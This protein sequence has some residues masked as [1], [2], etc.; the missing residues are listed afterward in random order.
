MVLKTVGKKDITVISLISLIVFFLISMKIFAAGVNDLKIISKKVLDTSGFSCDLAMDPRNG[1]LHVLWVSNGD[2]KHI[3]RYFSGSW[4]NI[5]T[6]DDGGRT[7]Y[8]QEE[9]DAA[10][11]C[12]AIDV[13]NTGKCHIVFA[14]AGGDIYYLNGKAGSWSEPKRIVSKG[15]YSIFTDIVWSSGNLYVVYEDSDPDKIYSV[16]C[17]NGKWGNPEM[18]ESG[19]YSE[20]SKGEDG[21]VYFLCRGTNSMQHNAKFGRI[22]PGEDKWIINKNVTDAPRRLGHGPG[23]AIGENKIYIAWNSSTGEEFSDKKTELYCAVADIP[24]DK[25]E[26]KL[27]GPVPIYYENTGDPHT[28]VAIFS[29]GLILYMNGARKERFAVWD[30][31]EWSQTRNAPWNDGINYSTKMYLELAND[32]RTVWVASSSAGRSNREVAVSA[33]VNPNAS[34]R[35]ENLTNDAEKLSIISKTVLDENGYSG[36]VAINPRDGSVHVIYVNDGDIYHSFK[37]VSSQNWSAPENIPDMQEYII[38]KESDSFLRFCTDID[39][40]NSGYLHVVFST[41]SGKVFYTEKKSDSWTGPVEIAETQKG[42]I[43][44]GLS[45]VN[46]VCTVVYQDLDGNLIYSVS[47]HDDSWTVPVKISEGLHPSVAKSSRGYVYLVFTG[48]IKQAYFSKKIPG[49]T[50]WTQPEI[51]TNAQNQ[52]GAEPWIFSRDGKLVTAWSNN[53]GVT[54]N[55]KSEMYCALSNEPELSWNLSI[56]DN[57]P[58]YYENTSDPHPRAALY[59]DGKILYLN[60]RRS[61]ERFMVINNGAWSETRPGPWGDGIPDVVSDGRTVWVVVSTT[62]SEGSEVSVSGITNP[63]AMATDY[64]NRVPLFISNPDTLAYAGQQ[65]SYTPVVDD[66]HTG[67]IK[68]S[69]I[70]SPDNMNINSATGKLTWTPSQDDLNKD[71]WEKG[72]GVFLAGI[73]VTDETGR[74]SSQYFWIYV[75]KQNNAP[76]ITSTP[77]LSCFVDS[78]FIYNVTASDPDGDDIT[79]SLMQSPAGMGISVSTGKVEWVPAI[80]DTGS[81]TIQI[82]AED[83]SGAFDAQSFNLLVK[84]VFIKPHAA[85]S[86]DKSE[87]TA[88]L[89]VNFTDESTGDKDLYFWNFGDDSTS[90][91]QNPVHTYMNAGLYSVQLIVTGPA[92]ADTLRKTDYITVNEPVP[93]A[94]FSADPVEGDMPVEVHFTDLSTGNITAWAWDFGDGGQSAE[95]NPVH[96]YSSSGNFTVTLVV[97]GP[98]GST[99]EVKES[100]ITVSDPNSGVENYKSVPQKFCLYQNYP[101]PFNGYTVIKY[102]IAEPSNVMVS[103]YSM[104]G[105]KVAELVNGYKQKGNYTVIWNGTGSSGNHIPSGI[106]LLRINAGKFMDKRKIILLK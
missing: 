59:S 30:G 86:C 27:G 75:N 82:K 36:R 51:I 72:S 105:K 69:I 96:T 53:T 87:G 62:G 5:E 90:S 21:T 104:M 28:R 37:S 71:L 89:T 23:M 40:D 85:F 81:H 45:V 33:I 16:I 67:S 19:E 46:G 93:A 97:T 83:S 15:P 44:T 55:F 7:V 25:W 79:F 66:E 91:L 95:Q 35:F 84:R 24:G 2:I 39:I 100:Y 17:K 58:M 94:D 18:L 106:Y 76:V 41:L 103:V 61:S 74:N 99:E 77:P 68:F 98:G 22:V 88:P 32:G 56:S 57:I 47:G 6:I 34:S 3:V 9:A 60:G 73:M 29:D 42:A 48:S 102:D 92:G 4:G 43:Y 63:D 31:N 11:K 10:R 20:L 26:S 12:A 78:L 50:S 38:G 1:N 52:V 14:S 101:N 70:T 49:Y 13:D 80:S 64:T 8:G 65:W 54:G